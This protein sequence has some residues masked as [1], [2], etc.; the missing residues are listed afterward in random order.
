MQ[1]LL[2]IRPFGDILYD[3]ILE[4]RLESIWNVARWSFSRLKECRM[5]IF[6]R[7]EGE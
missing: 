4:A 2:S 1:Q 3:V 7:E 6:G 5:E